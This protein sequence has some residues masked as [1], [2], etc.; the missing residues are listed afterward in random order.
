MPDN[1]NLRVEHR[2]NAIV[3]ATMIPFL[4]EFEELGCLT[5]VRDAEGTP[6]GVTNMNV[7]KLRAEVA[8]L[9]EES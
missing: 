1:L 9:R 3:K 2:A 5:L 4:E 8:R 6:T 7:E